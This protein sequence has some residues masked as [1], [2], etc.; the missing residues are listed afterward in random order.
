MSGD[1][2]NSDPS[3]ESAEGATLLER[4]APLL[5]FDALEC[6]RPTTFD[7][8]LDASVVL[9]KDYQQLANGAVVLAGEGEPDRWLNPIPSNDDLNSDRR[10]NL[11]LENFGE[12]G[13]SAVAGTCYGRVKK[14]RWWIYLQ[15]WFFYVDNPCILPPGRHDGDWEMVQLGLRRKEGSDPELRRVT[16]AQHGKAH[17]RKVEPGTIQPTVFVAVGSHASYLDPGTHP[18]LPIADECGDSEEAQT[19]TMPLKVELMPTEDQPH[20]ERWQGRWGMDRGAGT[21]LSLRLHL[22]SVPFFLRPLNHLGAG[23]SPASPGRQSGSWR[24]P[25]LFQKAGAGRRG[26]W[27]IPSWIAHLLGRATWPRKTPKVSVYRIN[28]EVFSIT[29]KPS[30]R[31]LRR[32]D[33]VMLQFEEHGTGR[34]LA[35]HTV[36]TGRTTGRLEH[37]VPGQIAWRAAGYNWLRQRGKL[38]NTRSLKDADWPL[39]VNGTSRA[40]RGAREVFETALARRLDRSG[41]TTM[42]GLVGPFGW[43]WLRLSNCEVKLVLNAARRDGIAVPLGQDRDASGSAIAKDEWS[44]TE[45]GRG[46]KR[47]RALSLPDLFELARGVTAPITSEAGKAEQVGKAV[48][49]LLITFLPFLA[50]PLGLKTAYA[51]IAVGVILGLA[52]AAGVRGEVALRRAARR[53]P[54]LQT[55]R[56]RIYRWQTTNWRVWES[57]PIVG[58][59]LAY[60]VFSGLALR[61]AGGW[62]FD[63]LSAF[64]ILIVVLALAVWRFGGAWSR[65]LSLARDYRDERRRVDKLRETEPY[66]PCVWGHECAAALDG[67][68]AYCEK[69]GPQAN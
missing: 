65:W 60:V 24:S 53:W 36:R 15:Y 42:N 31:L 61:L 14:G 66:H 22:K 67:R 38:T 40:D 50:K 59:A 32:V 1:P 8:Y 39:R 37:S 62:N 46:L 56:P 6:L 68:G 33:R 26:L 51:V 12:V 49:P 27:G 28:D 3:V 41:A 16:V 57:L 5:R 63:I 69:F 25:F 35:V 7:A 30:G 18:R 54:R 23:D 2:A 34:P 45:R 29:A 52:I 64:Q 43:F 17:T 11:L 21:W 9:D 58:I 47:I 20:W 48:T 19:P 10:S 55:C 13:G 44:V 4:H